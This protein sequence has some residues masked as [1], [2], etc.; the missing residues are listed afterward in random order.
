MAQDHRGQPSGTN[1]S[2]A[3]GVPAGGQN[4]DDLQRDQELTDRYTNDDGDIAEGVRELNPNR[5]VDK[6]DATNAGGYKQ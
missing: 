6:E 2:E 4:L 5:N 3:T 1:K